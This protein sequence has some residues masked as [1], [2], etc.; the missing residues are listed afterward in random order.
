[1]KTGDTLVLR[2]TFPAS[3]E[4]VFAMWTNE[5]LLK[6]WFCPGKDMTIPGA[7]VAERV[8]GGDRSE[9]IRVVDDRREE[10]DGRDERAV[11][12]D[13]VDGGVVVRIEPDDQVAVRQPPAPARGP[14]ADPLGDAARPP[15]RRA[16]GALSPLGGPAA[17]RVSYPTTAF[18][19]SRRW[20]PR[21]MKVTHSRSSR[22]RPTRSW[23][24]RRFS[25]RWVRC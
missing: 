8:G 13:A 7:E 19:P 5:E 2:R 10:V 23:S 4:R 21:M 25:R 12:R 16:P 11:L 14:P 15:R 1:M 22:S 24:E 20:R 9:V 3:C 18:R 17:R 6:K